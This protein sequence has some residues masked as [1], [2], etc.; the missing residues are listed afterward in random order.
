VHA[1]R[2]LAPEVVG[3]TARIDEGMARREA[4]ASDGPDL[5]NGL[6]GISIDRA[7]EESGATFCAAVTRLKGP[8]SLNRVW[9]AP[10][11]LPDK[12]ELRDP[13]AW[14]ERHNL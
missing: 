8:E 4:A 13:F 14:I 6:L 12:E 5:L 2:A 11:N 10:D 3:D 7:A 1:A 9:D